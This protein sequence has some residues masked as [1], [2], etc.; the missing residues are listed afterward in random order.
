MDSDL[1]KRINGIEGILE[2]IK[3]ISAK[4]DNDM[5]AIMLS[6]G[7]IEAILASLDRNNGRI[8]LALIGIIAASIGVKMLGT[9][10]LLDIATML[11]VIGAVLIARVLFTGFK[12]YRVNRNLTRSGWALGNLLFW[13]TATQIAVYFRDIMLLSAD[14]IYVI[15]IFQNISLVVFGWCVYSERHLY[16]NRDKKE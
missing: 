5:L 12:V 13:I 9:P 7:K 14:I 10:I 11:A 3:G 6:L 4:R 15:R 8:T 2:N 16:K 1:E